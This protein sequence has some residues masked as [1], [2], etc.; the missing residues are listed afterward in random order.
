MA[1]EYTSWERR[2]SLTQM[3]ML[4]LGMIGIVIL[5]LFP[6]T[7]QYFISELPTMF[8]RLGR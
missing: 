7:V 5:G 8:E 2:E 6:Q 4:G 3:S 1:E